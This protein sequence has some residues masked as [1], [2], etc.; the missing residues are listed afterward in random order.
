MSSRSLFLLGLVALAAPP[1][2]ARA[3][4]VERVAA[5]THWSAVGQN[6]K[7]VQAFTDRIVRATMRTFHVPEFGISVVQNGK[8][9]LDKGYGYADLHKRIPVSPDR[10]VWRMAS[11]A[12]PFTATAVMQVVEQ[13]R[14]ALDTNVNRY[15]RQLSIPDTYPLREA[16]AAYRRVARR[17]GKQGLFRLWSSAGSGGT[18]GHGHFKGAL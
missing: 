1:T 4:I 16:A 7:Q 11:I 9:V 3:A 2:L 14:L 13:G 6:P 17:L 5:S 15:L 8:V 12:V 10:T 18:I